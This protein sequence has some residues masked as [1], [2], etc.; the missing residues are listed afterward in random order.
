MKKLIASAAL[1]LASLITVHFV[2]GANVPDLPK[3][4]GANNWVPVS[5]RLGF[6]MEPTAQGGGDR[7]ILLATQPIRGYFV[8]K[9]SGGWVRL[10]VENPEG[11]SAIFQS[12]PAH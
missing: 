6:V 4:V 10:A 2:F 8:V 7:Q 1:A 11:V 3:G 5:D 9:T 12:Y